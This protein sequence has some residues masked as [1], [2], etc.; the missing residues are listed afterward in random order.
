MWKI[1]LL[2]LLSLGLAHAKLLAPSSEAKKFLNINLQGQHVGL[3]DYVGP[4]SKKNLKG[5]VLSFWSTTCVPCRKEMPV[6]QKW[7]ESQKGVVEVLFINV[8]KKDS[9]ESIKKYLQQIS[10]QG[11][12]LL[13]F[14]QTTAKSYGVCEGNQ[15]ALPAL[16]FI[17]SKGI[18]LHS[19]TGYDEAHDLGALL[20]QALKGNEPKSSSSA[21]IEV[22]PKA[23]AKAKALHAVLTGANHAKI[24]ESFGLTKA[25]LVELL[26]QVEALAQKQW[27]W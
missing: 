1:V 12:V 27:G 22:D 3:R 17:D 15:C 26:K 14:Y 8:D 5:I 2:L 18:I 6:L 13:D 11:N 4:D 25:E 19:Q 23:Q 10:L 21:A 9:L 20:D 24:A 16:Y 7:A